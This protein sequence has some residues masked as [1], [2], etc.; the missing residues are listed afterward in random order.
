MVAFSGGDLFDK[1]RMSNQLIDELR[2][3]E[4][5]KD[6][7][8]AQLKAWEEQ[9]QHSHEAA[10]KRRQAAESNQQ[11]Y[12]EAITRRKKD[13]S[14]MQHEVD[15]FP[16]D[17]LMVA[18]HNRRGELQRL[19]RDASG[20]EQVLVEELQTAKTKGEG[21]GKS[22]EHMLNGIADEIEGAQLEVKAAANLLGAAERVVDPVRCA[23]EAAVIATEREK[24]APAVGQ[25]VEV[26]AQES[27]LLSQ[28]F[29]SLMEAGNKQ[30]ADYTSGRDDMKKELKAESQKVNQA[31]LR[32]YQQLLVVS[33]ELQHHLARGTQH[34]NLS[35]RLT[36]KGQVLQEQ[37]L[38][39]SHALSKQ[40]EEIDITLKEIAELSHENEDANKDVEDARAKFN[41]A[42]KTR[43]AELKEYTD[44]ANELKEEHGRWLETKRAMECAAR[45]TRKVRSA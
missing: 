20:Q 18:L 1:E 2:K 17:T 13:I 39:T 16:A 31:L 7:E 11:P 45:A 35:T 37:V 15:N 36:G 43:D 14:N 4:A 28:K 26:I 19:V 3:E 32:E 23:D 21:L 38:E 41:E 34:K 22:C 5:E 33:Q 44:F 29:C 12:R 40:T 25:D 9:L 30:I 27:S 42:K 10:E 6:E 8:I 24:L